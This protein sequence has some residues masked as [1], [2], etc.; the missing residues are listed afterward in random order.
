MKRKRRAETAS[1][2]FKMDNKYTRLL[3][4]VF[5]LFLLYSLIPGETGMIVWAYSVMLAGL[6]YARWIKEAVIVGSLLAS[7]FMIKYAD[8]HLLVYVFSVVLFLSVIPI[9]F[10]FADKTAKERNKL[11]AKNAGLKEKYTEILIEHS[12]SCEERQKYEKNIERIMQLYI[13]GRDLLKSIYE[14]DF[15]EKVMRAVCGRAGVISVNIFLRNKGGWVPAAFSKAYHKNEWI[16]YIENNK[17]LEL[18]QRYIAAEVPAFCGRGESVVFWPLKIENKLLGCI[19]LV[20]EKAYVSRYTQEGAI[21]CPQIS[22]GA[23]RVSLFAEVSERSRNDGLTGLYLKRYF[24][25]RLRSEIRREKRYAGGFCILMMDIDHFKKVNDKYGH[26]AGDKVLCSIAK[27]LVDCVR[28][29]D[30]VGRYGGEEFIAFMPM[31]TQY[32]A[33]SVAYEINAAAAG[34]KFREKGEQFSVTISIGISSYPYGG[35]TIEQI[36][37]NADKA[38][39]KAKQEGRNKVVLYGG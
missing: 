34:K 14:Q 15:L 31:A 1:R 10:Y 28:P 19:L 9:P 35:K 33:R 32:E 30:L 2:G 4:T 3:I 6:C 23:K 8:G 36:I 13:T 26:L 16:K 39:Y 20:V 24:M 7:F 12:Y 18:E 37:G 27:I 22:L 17:H 11:S 38:L 5:V 21:M 29:G 25:E